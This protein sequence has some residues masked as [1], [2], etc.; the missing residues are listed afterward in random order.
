MPS[1][2]ASS[3]QGNFGLEDHKVSFKARTGSPVVQNSEKDFA[4]GD[5]I[6]NSQV[7]HSDA[8]SLASTEPPVAWNSN[9]IEE[10]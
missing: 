2:T 10:F 9:Q 8:S 1:S 7:R 4:K 5:T 3:S 6:K